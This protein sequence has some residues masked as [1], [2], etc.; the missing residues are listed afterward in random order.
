MENYTFFLYH[1]QIYQRF[2]A[3]WNLGCPVLSFLGFLYQMSAGTTYSLANSLL[4][5]SNDDVQIAKAFD[6][7]FE[8]VKLSTRLLRSMIGFLRVFDQQ[9]YQVIRYIIVSDI[10]IGGELEMIRFLRVNTI[11]RRLTGTLV[12]IS[13]EN[14]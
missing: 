6:E 14:A 9:F 2:E 1:E 4:A 10:I 8:T 5:G 3:G 13:Q 11:S 7:N 12:T